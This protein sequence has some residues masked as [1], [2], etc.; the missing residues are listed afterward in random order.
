[1][2]SSAL[3]LFSASALAVLDQMLFDP[4]ARG[5]FEWLSGG[6]MWPDE[7]PRMGTP[8]R[9]AMTPAEAIGCLLACRAAITLGQASPYLPI[10]EQVTQHAPHWP[11]LRPERRGE[12]ALRRLRA[13]LW[14]QDRCLAAIEGQAKTNAEKTD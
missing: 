1:M 4:K 11:G 10:W 14:R 12:A 8:E 9:R 3:P 6:L 2:N 5:Q 7:F 13:A